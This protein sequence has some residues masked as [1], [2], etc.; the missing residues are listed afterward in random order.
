MPTTSYDYRPSRYL[1]RSSNFSRPRPEEI[2][3]YYRASSF[4][5]SLD[6]YNNTMALSSNSPTSNS[7][8][9]AITTQTALPPI[10]DQNFLNCL[11]STIGKNLPLVK[12]PPKI[13]KTAIGGIIT[14]SVVGFFILIFALCCCRDC[15]RCCK[16]RSKK[17]STRYA[18]S[19]SPGMARIRVS[20]EWEVPE[21]YLPLN[22]VR[23]SRKESVDETW[24]GSSSWKDTEYQPPLKS[25]KIL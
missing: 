12:P 6:D 15:V 11:N 14:G 10:H 3:Q 21:D 17:K 20:N 1:D 13:S 24:P 5:L 16:G 22:A 18:R 2:I 4:A 9:P 7:T 8:P 25:S 23:K 19:D